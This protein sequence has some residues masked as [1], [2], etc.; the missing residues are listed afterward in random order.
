MKTG[1]NEKKLWE[2]IDKVC[3]DAV[4]V[5]GVQTIVEHWHMIVG[6]DLIVDLKFDDIY[7][8]EAPDDILKRIMFRLANNV[9][10]H[11]GLTVFAPRFYQY[12]DGVGTLY[13]FY[14][15]GDFNYEQ[16][17]A[18]VRPF[19]EDLVLCAEYGRNR[20]DN[21]LEVWENDPYAKMRE[22]GLDIMKKY[23]F[24]DFYCA[25]IKTFDEDP[26]EVWIKMRA[27][28]EVGNGITDEEI[29]ERAEEDLKNYGCKYYSVC[30]HANKGCCI[31]DR[32]CKRPKP[33]MKDGLVIR[34]W[35]E[36][37][38]ELLASKIN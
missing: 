33:V 24:N 30:V 34:R 9:P 7:Y 17:L 1:I 2:Y 35:K 23:F 26:L 37:H 11:F 20:P 22:N 14:P 10:K 13:S 16:A 8:G 12:Y 3:R 19:G 32:K 18:S 36:F 25:Y 15:N 29:A 31:E 4:R 5:V 38:Q 6:K 27:G 21:E 28:K